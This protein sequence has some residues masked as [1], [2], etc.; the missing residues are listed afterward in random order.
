M[1]VPGVELLEAKA[2][3]GCPRDAPQLYSSRVAGTI[4]GTRPQA[5]VRRQHR[6]LQVEKCSKK[7][8]NRRGAQEKKK[9]IT[10][11]RNLVYSVVTKDCKREQPSRPNL[12]KTVIRKDL[13]A[14]LYFSGGGLCWYRKKN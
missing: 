14:S 6:Q 12:G 2:A 3:A 11:Q 8:Q 7:K 13:G 1:Y 4:N 10:M 5:R 9:R